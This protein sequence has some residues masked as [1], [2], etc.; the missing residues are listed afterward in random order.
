MALGLLR[1]AGNAAAVVCDSCG[2]DHVEEVSWAGSPPGAE[3]RAYIFCPEAGRVRVPLDRL[4][5]WEIDFS[6]L[7]SA[8][9]AALGTAGQVEEIF[10]GR[11][12]LLGRITL[13]SQPR[14]VFLA[15]GLLWSDRTETVGKAARLLASP[16]PVVLVPGTMPPTDVWR[17][18]APQVLPLSA[19][20][21]CQGAVLVPDL[22]FLAGAVGR[23]RRRG[24]VTARSFPTPTGATWE[25]V[26][27]TVGEL[28]LDI[29]VR[30]KRKTFTFQ[31]AGFVDRRKG[32]APDMLWQLLRV[33]ALHGGVL[34]FGGRN[35]REGNK[36]SKNIYKLACRLRALLVIDGNPFKDSRQSRRY[37]TRFK[38]A[39]EEGVRFPTPE[40]A[41]WDNVALT[42]IRPGVIVAAVE[43]AET[44]PAYSIPDSEGG[45]PGRWEAA[46][47]T[48]ELVREYELRTLGLADD[49]GRPDARGE[50]LIAV[51]RAGGKVQRPERDSA[52]LGLCKRLSDLLQLQDTPFQ[53]FHGWQTW[54]ALFDASSTVGDTLR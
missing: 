24:T 21:S 22:A 2:G 5:R 28:R 9:S 50:A 53:F 32:C 11:I 14:E 8:V 48:G 33:L 7:A 43:I 39:A 12:W 29:D 19:L 1:A 17:G 18:D 23:G 10:P 40:G 4:R 31:E 37:E 15:R 25:D 6:G 51:L 47:R 3:P 26:R 36:L 38:V 13:A 20:L 16:R 49:N 34:P 30:G 45:G 27:L 42:E 46:E 35:R 44:F 54:S 41:G 52:M